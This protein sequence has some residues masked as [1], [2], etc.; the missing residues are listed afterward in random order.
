MTATGRKVVRDDR[1]EKTQRVPGSNRW[2]V[3]V[4]MERKAV[5]RAFPGIHSMRVTVEVV[6]FG[7]SDPEISGEIADR[8]EEFTELMESEYFPGDTDADNSGELS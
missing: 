5:D 3:R 7:A 1:N 2:D 6:V 8:I 4:E